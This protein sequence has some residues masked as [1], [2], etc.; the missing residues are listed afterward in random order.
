MKDWILSPQNEELRN[1]P[2]VSQVGGLRATQTSTLRGK[3]FVE[4][5][6]VLSIKLDFAKGE[7]QNLGY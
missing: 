4:I 3:Y 6:L 2:N 1:V 5:I 7:L